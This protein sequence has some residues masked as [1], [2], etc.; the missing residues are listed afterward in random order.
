[1]EVNS[2]RHILIIPAQIIDSERYGAGEVRYTPVDR[3]E[4]R[5]ID[6]WSRTVAELAMSV[7]TDKRRPRLVTFDSAIA[8]LDLL[9]LHRFA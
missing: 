1:M 6:P 7:S 2:G 5:W 8:F 4:I 9:S 3:W